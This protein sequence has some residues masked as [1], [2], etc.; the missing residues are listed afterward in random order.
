MYWVQVKKTKLLFQSKEKLRFFL[1]FIYLFPSMQSVPWYCY[2]NLFFIF[3]CFTFF[4]C[5]AESQEVLDAEL[6]ARILQ[7][8]NVTDSGVHSQV[9]QEW[10]TFLNFRFEVNIYLPMLHYSYLSL[11]NL[12]VFRVMVWYK[13]NLIQK[14]NSIYYETII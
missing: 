12:V 14:Q 13:I 6:S 5:S 10:L 1:F 8:I 9:Q 7:L 11:P 2:Y 4:L 3:L